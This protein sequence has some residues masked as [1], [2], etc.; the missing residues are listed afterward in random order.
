MI[1]NLSFFTEGRVVKIISK[2]FPIDS[3]AIYLR[4]WLKFMCESWVNKGYN[5]IILILKGKY[6][7]RQKKGYVGNCQRLYKVG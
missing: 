4:I 3:Q 7:G 1:W 2:S 6:Y 5:Q